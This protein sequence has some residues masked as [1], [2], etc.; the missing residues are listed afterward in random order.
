M[1][2]PLISFSGLLAAGAG[3]FLGSIFRFSLG[4]SLHRILPAAILPVGTMAANIIGC[5]AMGAL[6][7]L[8]EN[9]GWFG[10]ETKMFVFVGLLG[11]FTTF[12]TFSYETLELFR[13][14]QPIRAAS[15]ILIT[16]AGCLLA[17]WVGYAMFKK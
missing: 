12:S 2:T 11:A 9:H 3:G 14:D 10:T 5:L 8:D 6:A 16:V 13:S 1:S 15:N 7:A 17:V 4:V